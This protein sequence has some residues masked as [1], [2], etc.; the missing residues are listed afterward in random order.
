MTW[1]WSFRK[2]TSAGENEEMVQ[3]SGF[4][5]TANCAP[6]LAPKSSNIKSKVDLVLHEKPDVV[7]LRFGAKSISKAKL[8]AAVHILASE[9]GA[10]T[11]DYKLRQLQEVEEACHQKRVELEAI[12]KFAE[13]HREV[14][15]CIKLR[16]LDPGCYEIF[17]LRPIR[18]Q[19]NP[20]EHTFIMFLKIGGKMQ[21]CY[22]NCAI[23]MALQNQLSSEI[24]RHGD[25]YTLFD[26][27]IATLEITGKYQN[28]QRN[29]VVTCVVSLTNKAEVQ[30][31]EARRQEKLKEISEE[32][33]ATETA[34]LQRQPS[35]QAIPQ[36]EVEKLSAYSGLDSMTTLPKGAGFTISATGIV[37]HRGKE[38]LIIELEGK[39]YKAGEFLEEAYNK[40]ELSVAGTRI[41]IGKT[42]KTLSKRGEFVLCE[43]IPSNSW[44]EVNYNQLPY[45]STVSGSGFTIMDAAQKVHISLKTYLTY[46]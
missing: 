13:A 20:G 41:V 11:V 28:A 6:F 24:P 46:T 44:K 43:I 4:V 9:N 12:S 14:S 8:E 25:Y 34:A 3:Q 30:N 1:L 38:R 33:R 19:F 29:T 27:P 37:T 7:A 45:I 22:A 31:S 15:H 40:G 26:K 32:I 16:D 35:E 10:G 5:A 42:R 23:K 36:I 18:D 21:F 39:V 2:E 17:A